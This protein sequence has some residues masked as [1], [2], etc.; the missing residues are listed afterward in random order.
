MEQLGDRI[1]EIES[2]SEGSLGRLH[3]SK[4]FKEGRLLA[5][6]IPKE[7]H[8]QSQLQVQRA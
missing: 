7:E 2:L 6:K 8:M 4:N 3:P 1:M 5:T